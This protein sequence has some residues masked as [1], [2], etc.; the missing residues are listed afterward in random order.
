[1]NYKNINYWIFTVLLAVLS[2]LSGTYIQ[3]QKVSN[4]P[5]DIATLDTWVVGME[6]KFPPFE[7]ID[8]ATNQPKGVSVEIAN[9]LGRRLNKK[10]VIKS[11]EY[12]SLIPSLETKNIDLIISS[13]TITPER[14]KTIDFSEEYAKGQLSFAYNKSFPY[15][16]YS[17][18]NKDSVTIAV[19][20]G[21]VGEQWVKQNLPNAK[22]KGFEGVGEAML[23]VNN[24]SSQ[25]FIYDPLSLLQAQSGLDNVTVDKSPLPNVNGWGVGLRKNNPVAVNQINTELA[26]MKTD[27]FYD[28]LRNEYLKEEQAKY[29]QYGLEFYF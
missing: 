8:P 26:K 22:T 3:A 10:I 29:A 4:A 17:S 27:G 23:D 5:V 14:Q 1:M 7:T 24:N 28:K 25:A 16:N 9:E 20:K 15:E 13:M 6:L 11:T 2:F 19:K 18:L 21:T 12:P